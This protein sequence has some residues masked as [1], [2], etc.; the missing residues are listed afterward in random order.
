MNHT[1]DYN[2]LKESIFQ[3]LGESLP[4]HLSYHGLH[5][6]RDVLSALEIY[7]VEENITDEREQTLLRTGAV[8]HDCGFT[9]AYQN[10]EENGVKIARATLG[11]FG[12]KHDEIEIVASMILAT[13]VPQRPLS[14]LEEILCDCDLDYLGR[15]D[16]DKISQSLY[17]E[18][19]S[20]QMVTHP[21]EFEIKQ[22]RFME[23]HSY[24]TKFARNTR[25][26]RKEKTLKLLKER[27]K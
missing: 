8:L 9:I 12:Y 1:M 22:I 17:S 4:E 25:A 14:H 21:E 3:L 16:F 18:W 6:T 7:L 5:H 20:Y 19:K 10:H 23:N 2:S 11:D 24:F 13:K 27:I 15:E 26:P